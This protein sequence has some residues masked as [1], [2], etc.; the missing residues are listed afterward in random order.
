MS[1]PTIEV[2]CSQPIFSPFSGLPAELEDG[3]NIEDKTLLFIIKNAS[4]TAYFSARMSDQ[5][6]DDATSMVVEDLLESSSING[7]MLI[8]V[9]TGWDGINVYGFAP[10]EEPL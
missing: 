4:K 3:P 8:E 5:I 2:T 7:A 6:E 1:F 10:S 9:D